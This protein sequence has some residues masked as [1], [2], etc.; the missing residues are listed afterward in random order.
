MHRVERLYISIDG[1]PQPS[2][3][4]AVDEYSGTRVV[5]GD[6][7]TT[8]NI[9]HQ[10][11]QDVGQGESIQAMYIVD[12]RGFLMMSYPD[13]FEPRGTIKDLT[14]LLKYARAG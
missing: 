11:S 14:R 12:P 6:K 2:L 1:Q 5:Y 13:G 8:E 3:L 7:T 9:I 4:Q 10:F